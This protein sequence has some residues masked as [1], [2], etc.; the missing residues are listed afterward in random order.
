MKFELP[1]KEFKDKKPRKTL[2][3]QIVDAG[4]LAPY[5]TDSIDDQKDFRQF[6]IFEKGSFECNKLALLM[7]KKA[8]DKLNYVEELVA[9]KPFLKSNFHNGTNMLRFGVDKLIS[10][11]TTAPY[12]IIIVELRN[13]LPSEQEPLKRVLEDMRVK[14]D[15]FNLGFNLLLLP[16]GNLSLVSQMS[17]DEELM[18]LLGLPNK[19]FAINGCVIGHPKSTTSYFK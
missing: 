16:C 1:I 13:L 18:N 2:I 6:F 15:E 9:K 17:G 10:N 19:K 11:V 14:A 7:E 3:E 8:K 4:M 5:D 12:F